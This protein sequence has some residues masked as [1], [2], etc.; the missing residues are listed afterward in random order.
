GHDREGERIAEDGRQWAG[1]VLR[2]EDMEV[3]MFRL[4]LECGR[5][6]DDRRQEL[7]FVLDH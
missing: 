6:V 4:L 7:G 3:Y 2:K 5:I 1:R